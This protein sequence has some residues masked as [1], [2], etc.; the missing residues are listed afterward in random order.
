MIYFQKNEVLFGKITAVCFLYH[1]CFTIKT[2]VSF[3]SFGKPVFE[4]HV[5]RCTTGSI[6]WHPIFARGLAQTPTQQRNKMHHREECAAQGDSIK[7]V[8]E[9]CI[10]RALVQNISEQAKKLLFLRNSLH[11]RTQCLSNGRVALRR[12]LCG[13]ASWLGLQAGCLN[14]AQA[15]VSSDLGFAATFFAALPW[16]TCASSSSSSSL[17]SSSSPSLSSDSA[18]VTDFAA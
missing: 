15:P 13:R 4:N 6:F 2:L 12:W 1:L 5:A 14:G 10:A 8:E 9:E 16:E 11:L 18:P 17:S 7:V 3:Q